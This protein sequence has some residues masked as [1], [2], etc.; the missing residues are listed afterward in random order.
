MC[1]NLPSL[2][3]DGRG[4]AR[5]E[6]VRLLGGRLRN[7][8]DRLAVMGFSG[9]CHPLLSMDELDK[10][11]SWAVRNPWGT[12][13][14]DVF[15]VSPRL[16]MP[17]MPDTR[18][19][20]ALEAYR[21]HGFVQLG[22]ASEEGM[23]LWQVSPEIAVL[24]FF[25]V[26]IAGG[27]ARRSAPA[28]GDLFLVL[29]LTGLASPQQLETVLDGL[30]TP[31]LPL[32]SPLPDDWARW[33]CARGTGWSPSD[34]PLSAPRTDAELF[35]TPLL[36]DK[37]TAAAPLSRKRR[38]KAEEHERL[39]GLL[40]P[41]PLGDEV[42][43]EPASPADSGR[44]PVA[45]MLGDVTLAGA[46]FDVRLSGGRFL[47]LTG[48]AGALLPMRR[49]VSFLRIDGRTWT[50]RS[51]GSFS[52]ETEGGTG[53]REEL[54]LEGAGDPSASLSIE[55]SFRDSSPFLCIEADIRYPRLN[56]EAVVE[57]CVPFAIVVREL[58][59]AW[60]SVRTAAPDGSTADLTVREGEGWVAAP[61]ARQT[62]GLPGGHSLDMS[63]EGRWGLPF[64]RVSR[65]IG[66][67]RGLEVSPFGCM[68]G[69]PAH[70]LSG[71]RETFTLLLGVEGG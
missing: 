11:L 45:H 50:F 69:L 8:G 51:R 40:S 71:R 47:G 26:A 49:A 67:K 41:G 56:R 27:P 16:L 22:I 7:G 37:L 9:A 55:Y 70:W 4:R 62:V 57:E 42:S 52:F 6:L 5:K 48:R 61:G 60:A 65:C 53:L 15:G 3:A 19:P 33:K 10:E 64:F 46:G 17:R 23:R 2:P 1:W 25:R 54:A 29:D 38:K 68:G 20:L 12:G 63:W 13:L 32:V 21:K 44:V 34:A 66:R 36:R 43:A 39:L 18:R 28:R 59:G 30:V 14:A 31:L 24:P 35:P 58:S